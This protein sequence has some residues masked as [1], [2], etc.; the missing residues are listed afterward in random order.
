MSMISENFYKQHLDTALQEY[1]NQYEQLLAKYTVT[2]IPTEL[3]QLLAYIRETTSKL[4]EAKSIVV[5]DLQFDAKK[6]LDDEYERLND[7]RAKEINDL[8]QQYQSKIESAKAEYESKKIQVKEHNEGVTKPYK[9]KYDELLKYKDDLSS[10]FRRYGITPMSV[11]LTDDITK[12][13]YGVLVNEAIA[14]CQKYSVK[15]NTYVDKIIN[16]LKGQKNIQFTAA[17]ALLLFVGVYF[18]SPFVAVPAFYLLFKSIHGMEIDID[19]LKI[20]YALMSQ[21]DYNRF[22]DRS[23]MLE[24]EDFDDT[25]ILA[26]KEELLSN[27]VSY[28]ADYEKDVAN[29]YKYM[30]D[31]T[32]EVARCSGDIKRKVSQ[33]VDELQKKLKEAIDAKEEQMKNYVQFPFAQSDSVTMSHK[34]VLSR[35]ENTIDVKTEIPPVNIVFDSRDR[36]LAINRM[37]L[38]LANALLSVRVKQLTVEI[39]DPKNMGEDFVEFFEDGCK[40]YIKVNETKLEDLYNKY[41]KVAQDNLKHLRNSSIDEFNEDAEKRQKQPLEYVLLIIISSFASLSSNSTAELWNEFLSFSAKR[42]VM[43]WLL[44][45]QQH[46]GTLFVNNDA[47]MSGEPIH[48][49]TD[50]GENAA[51]TFCKALENYKA[52]IILYDQAYGPKFLPEEKWWTDT[53]IKGCDVRF[54]FEKADPSMGTALQLGDT[55]VHMLMAGSTGSGKSATIDEI[56]L[57]MI[58]QYPPSELQLI[59]IDFKNVEAA[60]YCL[61]WDTEKKCFMTEEEDARRRKAGEYFERRCT[62]PHVRLIAGTTDAKY[63]ESVFDYLDGEMK[64]RQ[65]VINKSGCQK[66]QDVR[67]MILAEYNKE[68]NGDPKKG[69]WLEMRRDWEWYKANVEDIY[70]DLSRIVLICDEFQVMFNP[71][72]V[73]SRTINSIS[74]KITKI[75]KLIRAMSGHFWF[76]SQSMTDTMSEDTMGQFKLRAALMCDDKVSNKILGNDASSKIKSKGYMYT[77]DSNGTDKNANKF[78]RIPYISGSGL[79]KY[80]NKLRAKVYEDPTEVPQFA[81]LYDEKVLAPAFLMDEWYRDYPEQLSDPRLFVLGERAIFST[82]KMPCNFRIMDDT[83]EH[84]SIVADER[85]DLLNISMTFIDNIK[86]KGDSATMILNCADKDAYELLGIDE[87]ADPRFVKISDENIDLWDFMDTIKCQCQLREQT[88]KKQKPLYVVLLYWEKVLS[89]D[90]KAIPKFVELLN[91]SAALGIHF[92]MS[93]G[94]LL[95][96]DS[97]FFNCFKHKLS[98]LVAKGKAS[99]FSHYELAEKLPSPNDGNG[100]FAMYE[101]STTFHKFKEYQYTFKGKVTQRELVIE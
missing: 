89:A 47:V 22:I 80:V 36:A 74:G 70:G 60:K 2:E 7:N 58:T 75:A 86:R 55:N 51:K 91:M 40:P 26:E 16:P 41:R 15:E 44:D 28:D 79:K 43:V 39:Y 25:P 4:N 18:L 76:T 33:I 9:D 82:N 37:K 17:Y 85:T 8:E 11:E 29:L 31:L 68:H 52:D 69:T 13:E 42:G 14:V 49:T 92:I 99:T 34:Y 56:M 73:D 67:E 20:A 95:E 88:T 21:V 24:T 97:F 63:A 81:V 64:R 57:S 10:V 62:I 3:S 27:V 46:P 12:K 94:A 5:S 50:I 101:Y 19:K 45:T 65:A 23:Q 48:Y 1:R 77:N 35:I 30:P 83:N 72:V 53:T 59:Y 100:C 93:F 38:Y 84:V 98:G 78:W 54:G 61:G 87:L 90:K 32:A 96:L 6:L 71:Q 66:I